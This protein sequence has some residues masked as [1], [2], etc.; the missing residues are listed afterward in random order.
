MRSSFPISVSKDVSPASVMGEA[1]VLVPDVLMI[2]AVRPL[3]PSSVIEP[4]ESE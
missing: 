1:T 3:P 2:L 4:P